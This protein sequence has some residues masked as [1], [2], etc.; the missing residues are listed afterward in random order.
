[1][2]GL[3]KY[4]E[5]EQKEKVRTVVDDKLREKRGKEKEKEKNCMWEM[6]GLKR[7]CA[8]ESEAER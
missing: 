2:R 1:M 7:R 6:R 5:K 8:K 3:K 4:V